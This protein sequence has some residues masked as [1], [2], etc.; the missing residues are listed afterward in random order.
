[1]QKNNIVYFQ[2]FLSAMFFLSVYLFLIGISFSYRYI[3]ISV[4]LKDKIKGMSDYLL[5]F[6]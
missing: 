6:Y 1:M 4:Y 5:S 3:L 2:F